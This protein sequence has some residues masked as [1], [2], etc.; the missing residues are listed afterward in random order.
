MDKS[1]C[2]Y[3]ETATLGEQFADAIDSDT[4]GRLRQDRPDGSILFGG[5]PYAFS[6]LWFAADS[7]H[8]ERE[9]RHWLEAARCPHCD[10]R[11]ELPEGSADED[12]TSDDIAC[13]A[14]GEPWTDDSAAY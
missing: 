10:G 9:F 2:T 3:A 8:Y 4:V 7:E 12:W 6:Y 11:Y 1:K 13:S 5:R 14:C